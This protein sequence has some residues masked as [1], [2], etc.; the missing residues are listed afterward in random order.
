[1]VV[2]KCAHANQ[3]GLARLVIVLY[4]LG[5]VP[6]PLGSVLLYYQIIIV[7]RRWFTMLFFLFSKFVVIGDSAYAVNVDVTG[8][9]SLVL[10]VKFALEM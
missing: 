10:F 3:I 2:I 7:A 8:L 4:L 6:A 9:N 5:L 1:M